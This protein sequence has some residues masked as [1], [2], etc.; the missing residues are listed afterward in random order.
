[1]SLR[2]QDALSR[3][4]NE[5]RYEPTDKRVRATFGEQPVVDT[6]R[7]LVVWEPRRVVPSYAV[8]AA[9]VRGDLAPSGAADGQDSSDAPVL[10]PGFPFALH[11]AEGEP[12]TIDAAGDARDGVGFRLADPDL[13]GYVILDFDGFDAWFEED[14]PIVGHP[15]NPFHRIDILRS[16]RAIRLELD[17]RPLAE[18]SRPHLLFETG[19][20]VRYYLP[21]EDVLAELRPSDT[22]THCAYKGRASYW[23]LASG[24]GED[25][26]WTY[27]EPLR[28]AAEITGLLAFFNERVDVIV[29]GERHERP[30]T[31]WS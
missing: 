17:G 2:I 21:Q 3:E 15:R 18:T 16:S 19:L 24:G 30:V 8:P 14:E 10:H 12:V 25:L 22:I 27:T 13:E 20:P 6:V 1:M 7:A 4:L 5:L 28:E 11:T 26:V 9:D 29:D 31:P 23:S